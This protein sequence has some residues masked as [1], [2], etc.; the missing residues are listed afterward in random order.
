MSVR[1]SVYIQTSPTDFKRSNLNFT[2]VLSSLR[3]CSFV[4]TVDIGF[5]VFIYLKSENMLTHSQNQ[6]TSPIRT[7]NSSRLR[8]CTTRL[9]I[10]LAMVTLSSDKIASVCRFCNFLCKQ[11]PSVRQSQTRPHCSKL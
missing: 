4:G 6:T 5:L 10:V 1:L 2:Q 9:K 11:R 3:S 8:E 7:I